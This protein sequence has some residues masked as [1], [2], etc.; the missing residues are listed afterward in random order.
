MTIKS[1]FFYHIQTSKAPE[2]FDKYQFH[3]RTL[4][5]RKYGVYVC[6]LINE[7]HCLPASN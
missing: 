1:Y 6:C 7:P 5:R 2:K 4:V 3:V